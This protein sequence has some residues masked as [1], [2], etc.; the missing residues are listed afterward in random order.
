MD[1]NWF[2]FRHLQLRYH[3]SLEDLQ[4]ERDHHADVIS[5]YE[6][7]INHLRRELKESRSGSSSGSQK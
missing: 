6:E 3:M 1:D 5:S 7:E 4:R 2:E